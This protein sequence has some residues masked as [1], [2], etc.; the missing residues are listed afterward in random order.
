[1]VEAPTQRRQRARYSRLERAGLRRA[2]ARHLFVRHAGLESHQ[3]GQPNLIREFLQ[4]I[5]E[6]AGEANLIEALIRMRRRIGQ[7]RD[8]IFVHS[9]ANSARAAPVSL[10][11]IQAAVAGDPDEP[12]PE[13]GLPSEPREIAERLEKDLL[14]NILREHAVPEETDTVRIHDVTVGPH[15][16]DER[17][18]MIATRDQG[19]DL[20]VVGDRCGDPHRVPRR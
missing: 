10:Y 14:V 18:A 6:R 1:M 5:F 16:R 11:G 2:W 15:E 17:R 4:T 19:M 3:H 8:G 20:G 13:A 12:G 7:I 9:A